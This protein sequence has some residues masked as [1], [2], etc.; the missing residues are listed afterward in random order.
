MAKV[1][2][3][4]IF[5]G[6]TTGITTYNSDYTMIGSLYKQ[7]TGATA[8]DNYISLL[9][10]SM[11]N[12]TDVAGSTYAYPYV[13]KWSD[14]IFWVFMATTVTAAATRQFGLFEYDLNANTTTWKGFIT[15]QGTQLGG[16]KTVRG[17]RTYVYETTGGTVSATT[18]STITGSGTAFQTDRIAVGARIG[19]GS[20]DPTQISTWYEITAIAS[21][22]SLTIGNTVTVS[23]GSSYVIEEIRLYFLQT[24]ATINNG[25]LYI[26]KGLNY[27]TFALGGNNIT[28]STTTDNIRASYLLKDFTPSTVTISQASPGVVTLVSHGLRL[29]DA[30][31]FTTTGALPTGFVA[32]TTYYVTS[33]SLAAN[34]FTLSATINGAPINTSTAGSGVHTLH[35]AMS[36]LGGGIGMDEPVSATEHN[37]YLL[38]SEVT[39]TTARL[40][41]YNVKASLTPAS[42]NGATG[43][44]SLRTTPLL[45][46]GTISL[47][48]NGRIVAVQHGSASGIKSFY[49]ATTTRIY[50]C[51]ES[52]ILDNSSSFLSDQMIEIPP[53]GL[54]NAAYNLLSSMASVDYSSTLDRL[55]ITT[56]TQ[57]FGVYAAQYNT[58]GTLPFDKIFAANLN[59]YKLGYTPVGTVDGL[60]P[61]ATLTLWSEAGLFFAAPVTTTSGLNWLLIFPG[62]GD[63]YFA[64]YSNERVITP[65][66]ATPNAS[67]LYR[68][69]V[70]NSDYLGTY[71]LGFPPDPFR[72]FF[73]TA[74]IDDNTGSW[75]EVPESGDLSSFSP[76]THIQFMLELDTLGEACAPTRIYAVTCLYDDSSTD[77]HY[78]PS[79]KYSDYVNK[80]FAWWF[81]L[82]W[83]STVPTLR[84]RLYDAVTNNLLVDDNTG[85]PTGTFEKSTDG[86][87]TWSSY[88][89]TDRANTTTYIRYTPASL[90]DN[91]KVKFILT[92]N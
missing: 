59:R 84:V 9:P 13:H 34:T 87:S 36:V 58:S 78:Q 62:G 8:Q 75:T 38:N 23:A 77:V 42:A 31:F 80:R 85:S 11:V 45:V 91:I 25:G 46:T 92:Q 66:M 49:F 35:S 27:S 88:D 20:T 86:G 79:I 60:F 82:A 69:Y 89:N 52:T 21:D 65:K 43:A 37:V 74:G 48:N 41:K 81:A 4:H 54:A 47:L 56:T 17:F 90:G 73:R 12:I 61:Q 44:L 70:E 40:V 53:G 50:R 24:N 33:T 3:E 26:I 6:S 83:G 30:V 71:Q 2:V 28:E 19:F 32:N 7:F 76:S 51:T 55:L 67:K 39:N 64:T 15:L 72:I 29:N 5:T 68:A 63:G 22:T 10:T 57:R 1:A 16:S 14:N 18:S